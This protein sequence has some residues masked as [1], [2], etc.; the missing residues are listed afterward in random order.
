MS[1]ESDAEV[2]EREQKR[3]ERLSDNLVETHHQVT[4]QGR[5][6]AY[7]ATTGTIILKEETK[8][9]KTDEKPPEDFDE[10]KAAIFFVAYT[11]DGVEDKHPAHLLFG[12]IWDCLDLA[13]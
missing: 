4:V 11:L 6:L 2:V 13:G 9:S 7:T 10:P 3:K 5:T 1:P 8:G 12:C